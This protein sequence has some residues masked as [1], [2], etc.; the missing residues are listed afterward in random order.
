MMQFRKEHPLLQEEKGT[1][2]EIISLSQLYSAMSQQACCV[3]KR[4]P[5]VLWPQSSSMVVYFASFMLP[6]ST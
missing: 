4:R 5:L 2:T 3:H 1:V 6:F